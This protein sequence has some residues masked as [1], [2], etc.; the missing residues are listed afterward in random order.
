MGRLPRQRT[1]AAV[2]SASSRKA[3][4]VSTREGRR[5]RAGSR[6]QGGWPHRLAEIVGV[7]NQRV[8]EPQGG[9]IVCQ[10]PDRPSRLCARKVTMPAA[11]Q[12]PT[13]G[14]FS[15]MSLRSAAVFAPRRPPGGARMRPGARNPGAA[16]GRARSPASV[17]PSAQR[18]QRRQQQIA[19]R[20]PRRA[21]RS[22]ASRASR[23][24]DPH[25]TSCAR[26]PRPP[27][28]PAAVHPKKAAARPLARSPGQPRQNQKQ[29]RRVQGVQQDARHVWPPAPAVEAH[30]Q[31]VREPGQR[32]PVAGVK[33][34][35]RP[36]HPVHG[37]ARS[38]AGFP[39]T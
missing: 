34:G 35:E 36:A 1:A 2:I 9:G 19:F 21:K 39:S 23:N 10:P 8:R 17:W 31:H 29:E 14:S 28:P 11:A 26:P 15:T 37:Q 13:R 32:V 18:E 30:V 25:S 38:T 5:A 4:S 24:N 12:R 20:P 27:T 33:G 3:P 6:R 16:A 22:Y 7:R